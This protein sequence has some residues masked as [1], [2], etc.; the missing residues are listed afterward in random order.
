MPLLLFAFAA[1]SCK[2]QVTVP[3][4]YESNPNYSYMG[5]VYYGKYYSGNDNHVFSL[6]FYSDGMVNDD[7]T[8]VEPPGQE[9]YIEDLFVPEENFEYLQLEEQD[10]LLT[11][12]LALSLL[13][14]TYNA[15]GTS[16]SDTFG[17]SF[18]FS[19][20]EYVKIDSI[21]YILGARITYYE[22]DD[23]YSKRVLITG[24][25]FTISESGIDFNLLTEDGDTL[26]GIYTASST[27][28]N[29]SLKYRH[30][31]EATTRGRTAR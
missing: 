24:G 11:E 19:P 18:T 14:G 28:R 2:E 25:H 22:E 8:Y 7:S 12:R 27:L 16:S 3:Y 6:V 30:S 29:V 9:L 20:G 4:V 13:Q 5:I 21:T 17:D 23:T 10:T 31:K 15:S 1:L 26:G